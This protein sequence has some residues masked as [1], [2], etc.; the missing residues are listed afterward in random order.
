MPHD[1]LLSWFCSYSELF[2][3]YEVDYENPNRTR[4]PR[5]SAFVYKE[6]V[7]TRALDL[8][9]EPDIN[10]MTIDEGQ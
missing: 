9:Y 1:K 10:A 7:R 8:N 2:G 5:K 6:I 4:T 3:L